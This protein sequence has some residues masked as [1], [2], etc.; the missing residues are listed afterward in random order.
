MAYGRGLG[1]IDDA[2]WARF[3]AKEQRIGAVTAYL[4][5]TKLKTAAGDRVAMF[6]HLKKPEIEIKDVLEYGQ[7]PL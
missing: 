6:E 7:S 3:Q 4:K 2:T 5:K 1:L